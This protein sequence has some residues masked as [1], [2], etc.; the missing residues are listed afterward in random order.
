[1]ETM[2]TLRRTHYCGRLRAADAG[3]A[4]DAVSARDA[5]N[6]DGTRAPSGRNGARG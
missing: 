6:V 2:G 4:V 1:M 5:G 3:E